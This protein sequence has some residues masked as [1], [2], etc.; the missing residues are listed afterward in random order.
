MIETCAIITTVPNELVR[1]IH[2]RMPAILAPVDIGSWL[3]PRLADSRDLARL[4]RPFAADAMTVFP[5][6]SRVN[7]T[8]F[9]D[10]DCIS[11]LPDSEGGEDAAQLSLGL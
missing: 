6:T 3:D 7:N 1:A 11:P 10:P 2:D 8:R 4:L 9:D 5:V